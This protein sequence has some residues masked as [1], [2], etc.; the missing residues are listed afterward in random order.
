MLGKL[1]GKYLESV[2][3]LRNNQDWNNYL[4]WLN[5]NIDMLAQTTAELNDTDKILR[6][7]GAFRAIKQNWDLCVDAK[8]V[9]DAKKK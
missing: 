8:N 6:Y 9:L 2:A 1:Q 5:F 4:E 7:Q 3:R